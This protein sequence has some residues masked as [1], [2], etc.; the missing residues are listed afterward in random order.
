MWRWR[1]PALRAS[2][3]VSISPTPGSASPPTSYETVFEPFEQVD[4]S[5]TRRFGGT[6]L[7]LAISSKLVEMMGGRIGV[8]S[9]P[10]IGTTFWFTTTLGVQSEEACPRA[11]ASIRFDSMGYRSSSSTT[12]PPTS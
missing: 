3:S 7:G 2:S 4:G 11:A 1:T 9:K 10:G 12:M 5:T 6:G 8:D